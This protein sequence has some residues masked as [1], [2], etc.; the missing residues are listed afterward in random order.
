MV[1]KDVE[2]RFA[3]NLSADVVDYSRLVGDGALVEL[4][5]VLNAV[6]CAVV[7]QQGMAERI[8]RAPEDERIVFR[9]PYRHLA[10]SWGAAE[11]AR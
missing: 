9:I 6:E 3:A 8:L 5:I 1:G 2:R 11:L 10:V 4:A 7:V